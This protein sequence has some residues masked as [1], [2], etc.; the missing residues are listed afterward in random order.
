[1]TLGTP[2][3]VAGL[4]LL[5][6][7]PARAESLLPALPDPLAGRVAPAG[8]PPVRMVWTKIP[9]PISLPAGK[10]RLVGF[11]VDVRVGMPPE[12][13]ADVLRTQIVNGTVY[14][15]A[16]KEFAVQRVEVQSVQDG[17]VYL[18][19]LSASKSAAATP[20]E[21][22]LPASPQASQALPSAEKPL[23]PAPPPPQQQDYAT[24]TRMAAQHLYAPAR[25]HRVPDGVYRA[26]VA[27]ESAGALMRGGA[28]EATP[29]SAW[30]SG[31]L[32]VTAVKIRNKTSSDVTLDPRRLRGDWL[33]CAFQH[34]R[35]AP[36][37]DL[38]DTTAAYLISS[39]P[40]EEAIRGR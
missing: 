4:A 12:L 25:L 32:Y 27:S 28:I 39:R 38:R 30:R 11:P 17:N 34:A 15:T 22:S 33:T 1:M 35:L 21:V 16:L 23:P 20:I 5:G 18:I 37:G 24:L 26:P 14:W 36:R 2:Y 6:A 19:D 31:A 8:E 3:I 40:Y 13:G 10:E 9:L 7:F 29:L